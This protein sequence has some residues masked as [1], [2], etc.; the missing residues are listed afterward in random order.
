M[1]QNLLCGEP[2]LVLGGSTDKP[3]QVLS[4]GVNADSK[5]LCG[6]RGLS[7]KAAPVSFFLVG[8]GD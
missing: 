7:S 5:S 2:E 8:I 3:N 6:G 1:E 4:E